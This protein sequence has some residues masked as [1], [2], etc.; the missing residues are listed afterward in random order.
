MSIDTIALATICETARSGWK[1]IKSKFF[2]ERAGFV[3]LVLVVLLWAL[4]RYFFED[5]NPY[6]GAALVALAILVYGGGF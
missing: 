5:V 2:E 1:E 3:G 6:F 4:L